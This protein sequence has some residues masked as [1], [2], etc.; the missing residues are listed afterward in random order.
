MFNFELFTLDTCKRSTA[1]S[2]M[3]RKLRKNSILSVISPMMPSSDQGHQF[4]V[5]NPLKLSTGQIYS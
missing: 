3:V 4:A 2:Y 1:S 5:Y